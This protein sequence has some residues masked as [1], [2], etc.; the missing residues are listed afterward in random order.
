MIYDGLLVPFFANSHLYG[1]RRRAAQKRVLFDSR[2]IKLIFT[3]NEAPVCK[4]DM[5]KKY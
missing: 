2:I 3:F 4:K 5:F 1:C